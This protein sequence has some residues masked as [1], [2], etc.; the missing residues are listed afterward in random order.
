MLFLGKIPF[1]RDSL[2][3]F[4]SWQ[5]YAN[6]ALFA[7]E[8]PLWNN[9]SGCGTPF[10][11]NLQ[12]AV[13]YPLKVFFLFLP[14]AV[15]IKIFILANFVLAACS[16][17]V[18]AKS[19]KLTEEASFL[20]AIIFTFNA[21]MV[22][23]AEFWCVLAAS[24]LTPLIMLNIKRFIDSGKFKHYLYSCITLSMPI[25]AGSAQVFFYT[26][27][28]MFAFVIWYSAYTRK[29]VVKY[30]GLFAGMLLIALLLSAVQLL[31]FLEFVI[32]SARHSGL[33]YKDASV[34]SLHPVMLFKFLVPSFWGNPAASAYF[35]GDGLWLSSFY[36]STGVVFLVSAYITALLSRVRLSAGKNNSLF[37]FL[38]AVFLLF[39]IVSLGKYGGLHTL[40]YYISPVFKMIR[41]P[42][43]MIGMAVFALALLSG[44]LLDGLSSH[45]ANKT[46]AGIFIK[47]TFLLISVLL[48]V[49]IIYGALNVEIYK[50]R[51]AIINK[52]FLT[53]MGLILSLLSLIYFALIKRIKKSH[54]LLAFNLFVFFDLF[55][56]SAGYIPLTKTEEVFAVPPIIENIKK[57]KTNFRIVVQ[58]AALKN[59]QMQYQDEAKHEKGLQ[60]KRYLVDLKD[61]LHDNYPLML[62][63]ATFSVYD[64]MRLLKQDKLFERFELQQSA[65]ETQLLNIS[66][67]KY[68]IAGSQL[69]ETGLLKHTE[70]GALSVYENLEVLPRAFVTYNTVFAANAQQAFQQ[71]TAKKYLPA[72]YAVVESRSTG[73][74]NYKGQRNTPA[75]VIYSG[76][77]VRVNFDSVSPGLL[78]LLDSYYAGWEA[79]I[80]GVKSEIIRTNYMFRGVLVPAGK[81]T[82]VFTYKPLSFRTGVAVSFTT[83]V[84][85]M[86]AFVCLSGKKIYQ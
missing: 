41:Y 10:I 12:S 31:P 81:H 84:F 82:V 61:I 67:T 47:T 39:L 7:G 2:L 60:T 77:S 75:D 86:L 37:Y 53:S 23:R 70:N 76:N 30:A 83:F 13:F 15:A 46:G 36:C 29:A 6:N 33:N 42:A 27:M 85:L 1:F 51:A 16:M 66:N 38:V 5:A 18:L 57:D 35:G 50:S 71:V 3:S 25:F 22:S 20:A 59:F 52:A 40:L 72:E 62:G 69:K 79:F 21:Y 68:I 78:V 80:G 58:P 28:L 8:L 73:H 45:L 24:A 26:V 43:T 9:L 64:P 65:F 48:A 4:F 49:Y 17:F 34:G 14:F 32:H 74:I 11:A 19:F 63:V 44:I 56:N 54:F 55:V